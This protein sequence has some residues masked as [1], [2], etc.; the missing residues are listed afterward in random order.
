MMK[1]YKH[2]ET[3]QIAKFDEN[4]QPANIEEFED[5]TGTSEVEAF[6]VQQILEGMGY[7]V[8][9]TTESSTGRNL[10]SSGGSEVTLEYALILNQ[11]VD[12]IE[13]AKAIRDELFKEGKVDVTLSSGERWVVRIDKDTRDELVQRFLQIQGTNNK[14]NFRNWVDEFTETL[15][16]ELDL[17]SYIPIAGNV[18]D[19]IHT[20]FRDIG[21]KIEAL[22]TQEDID[23]FPL[24]E[25]LERLTSLREGLGV[26][27]KRTVP[28]YEVTNEREMEL[29]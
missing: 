17:K 18:I 27:V 7:E 15:V 2:K 26:G 13:K 21:T 9:T 3:N 24:Q 20:I 16:G 5:I 6:E 25:E 28:N 12:M 10:S 14:R 1:Y 22:K 23:N 29:S 8:E 19:N 11:Q 4:S